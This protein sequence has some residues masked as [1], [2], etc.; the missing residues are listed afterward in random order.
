MNITANY[1]TLGENVYV[2]EQD[3]KQAK[4]IIQAFEEDSQDNQDEQDSELNQEQV[5]KTRRIGAIAA[6]VILGLFALGFIY[7]ICQSIL[8]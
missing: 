1:S 3:L 4:E 2:N 7:S 5:N 8:F 6:G